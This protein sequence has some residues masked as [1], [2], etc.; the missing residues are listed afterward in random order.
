MAVTIE[1]GDAR[2]EILEYGIAVEPDRLALA[3]A[4]LDHQRARFDIVSEYAV[5][6][7]GSRRGEPGAGNV[8]MTYGDVSVGQSAFR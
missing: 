1:V 3:V 7:A 8:V 2:L 5:I 6:V 4:R